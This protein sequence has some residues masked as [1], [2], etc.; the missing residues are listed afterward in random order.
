M[1]KSAKD[2]VSLAGMVLLIAAVWIGMPWAEMNFLP[3]FAVS[4]R[5]DMTPRLW[6]Y[7]AAGFVWGAYVAQMIVHTLQG[8][9]LFPYGRWD[10]SR[11]RDPTTWWGW[12]LVIVFVNAIALFVA[13][14][15]TTYALHHP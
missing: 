8:G 4:A 15:A 5:V 2:H 1:T 12:A 13:N 14:E 10:L 6:A 9:R 3:Y 11:H 7:A